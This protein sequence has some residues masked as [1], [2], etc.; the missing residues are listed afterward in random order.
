MHV[1]Y[2]LL[3]ILSELKIYNIVLKEVTNQSALVIRR[4][5]GPTFSIELF[6]EKLWPTLYLCCV[7]VWNCAFP[8]S[9]ALLHRK[10]HFSN[11]PLISH[12]ILTSINWA[13]AYK[14]GFFLTSLIEIKYMIIYSLIPESLH[15]L[16]ALVDAADQA[17]RHWLQA[18]SPA[19]R[20]DP[21]RDRI[22]GWRRRARQR[23]GCDW[24]D[25][26]WV[27]ESRTA[28]GS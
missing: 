22:R 25:P 12:L 28:R 17:A 27:T 20:C 8:L 2:V 5:I 15:Q 6:P 18:F 11:S 23:S 24:L 10:P 21:P 4:P 9:K 1:S 19:N 26:P 13:H 14:S 7:S 16:S 3:P